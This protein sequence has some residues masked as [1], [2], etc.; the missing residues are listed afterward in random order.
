MKQRRRLVWMVSMMS[1]ISMMALG[2][3]ACQLGGIAPGDAR[4]IRGSGNVVT[5]EEAI[6]GFDSLDVSHGFQVDVRQGDTFGVV[7]RVDDNL[8]EHL[9]VL[10]QGS[11]LKIGLKPESGPLCQDHEMT[12]RNET[13]MSIPGSLRPQ[14]APPQEA[15]TIDFGVDV[16]GCRT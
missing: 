16:H 4:T 13:L 2:I 12:K 6:T 1:M 11:T 8:V 3:L 9:R 10:K 7:I 14:N 15:D 5:Q